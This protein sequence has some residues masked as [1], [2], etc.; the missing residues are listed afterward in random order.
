M[1][2]RKAAHHSGPHQRLARLVVNAANANPDTRCARCG[3]TL[4]EHPPAK[5]GRPPRWTAGH[6][7]DGK[8]AHTTRDYQPEV[9]TCGS[10]AGATH[11]NQLREPHS[12]TW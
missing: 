4:A 2:Y 3:L 12:R 8:V 7:V 5:T 1:A 11:G 10:S 9:D 6:K